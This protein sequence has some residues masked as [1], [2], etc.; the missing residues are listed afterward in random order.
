[1]THSPAAIIRRPPSLKMAAAATVVAAA[2]DV[3]ATIA[4]T[5][6][7]PTAVVIPIWIGRIAL[8]LA[9]AAV[10]RRHGWLPRLGPKR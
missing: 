1:M 10:A 6:G 9:A 8:L 7:A 5:A 4:L 2:I 3:V